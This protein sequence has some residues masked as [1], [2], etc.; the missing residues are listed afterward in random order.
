MHTSTKLPCRYLWSIA[1]VFA[2]ILW[3]TNSN[4]T[5][6]DAISLELLKVEKV[7][8]ADLITFDGEV[9]ALHQATLASQTAGRIVTLAYDVGDYVT[10]GSEIASLTSVAQA[11]QLDAAL[12]Q[13]KEAEAFLTEAQ[14]NFERSRSVYTKKLIPKAEFDRAQANLKTSQAKA[15]A[16]TAAV[17]AARENLAYTTISAPF[18]GIVLER[19]VRVGETVAPGTPIMS[20]ISLQE[21]RVSVH[22]PQRHIG[23][24]RRY[25]TAHLL[26]PNNITLTTS[27]MRI[28][29][30]A[31]SDSHTFRVLLDLPP[32]TQAVFPGT[33]AKVQFVCGQQQRLMIPTSALL[34]RG[35]VTGVYLVNPLGDVSLRYVRVGEVI[36]TQTHILAGLSEGEQIAL[37]PVLAAQKYKLQ[38]PVGGQ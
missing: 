25:Q 3:W 9:E 24:V 8:T 22:V 34:H 28:P 37:N 36:G 29:P 38:N 19:L 17:N 5:A 20:G 27:S 2:G 15:S 7:E 6:E 23:P 1:T 33:L 13:Q 26:L 30:S 21:L 31:D 14:Q 35:E 18:S 12:S 32:N 11:A 10:A 16:A 4:A